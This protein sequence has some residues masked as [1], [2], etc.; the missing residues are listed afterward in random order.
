M[1]DALNSR[2]KQLKKISLSKD[3]VKRVSDT[4]PLVKGLDV[5]DVVGKYLDAVLIVLGPSGWARYK[6][7]AAAMV[8]AGI[9]PLSTM[10]KED[11][12]GE[13]TGDGDGD[14]D[15]DCERNEQTD[16]GS[17]C[18][19]IDDDDDNDNDNEQQFSPPKKKL[20]VSQNVRNQSASLA[21][22][23]VGAAARRAR[24]A[25]RNAAKAAAKTNNP[26][27]VHRNENNVTI[28]TNNRKTNKNRKKVR[29]NGDEGDDGGNHDNEDD[30][31]DEDV[32]QRLLADSDV[33]DD[34]G[35][36]SDDDGD[37]PSSALLD[38][39]E[40]E[41]RVT[42][43]SQ[44][45]Y[46]T[47]TPIT[48]TEETE[49]VPPPLSG[50]SG[51]ASSTMSPHNQQQDQELWRH[52][53]EHAMK[54]GD[55]NDAKEEDQHIAKQMQPL[56]R[57]RVACIVGHGEI[58]DLDTSPD[59][60]A[61]NGPFYKT[62]FYKVLFQGFENGDEEPTVLYHHSFDTADSKALLAAYVEQYDLERWKISDVESTDD[63]GAM[64]L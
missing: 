25:R 4:L 58:G 39:A 13:D 20:R 31:E 59:A 9:T 19:K 8:A 37:P 27:Y 30:A 61:R 41:E 56:V 46:A 24:T 53:Q 6:P 52:E 48:T 42:P 49:T 7:S 63:T 54:C 28:N 23:T 40:I 1:R 35:C 45:I 11:H 16:D 12:A 32:S 55:N 21:S 43:E 33:D 14:A 5:E 60:A 29:D 10:A 44:D 57:P 64:E 18:S 36:N 22:P 15:G 2:M 26:T 50:A 38:L 47:Q 62:L 17:S 51:S 34:G 3:V